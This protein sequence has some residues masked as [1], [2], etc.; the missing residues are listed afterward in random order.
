MLKTSAKVR[1]IAAAFI[2]SVLPL[3]MS[4]REVPSDEEDPYFLLTGQAAEAID[5]CDYESA[6]TR[7]LEAMSLRPDA[8]ENV[9]L[10]S[11]LG[12]VYSYMDKDSLALITF[13]RALEIAPSMRTVLANRAN[14]Y[15]KVGR[16]KDAYRDLGT[17]IEIDSTSVDARYLHG[18]LAIGF[19]DMERAKADMAVVRDADPEGLATAVG[20]STIYTLEEKHLDA[21]PYL[22]RLA[23]ESGREEDFAALAACQLELGKLSDAGATIAKG[24]GKF[25]LSGELY[26]YRARLNRDRYDRKSAEADAKKARQLGIEEARI[27]LLKL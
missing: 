24:M 13:D 18:L 2:L 21:L 27:K 5:S 1:C 12:M 25:P 22:E 14:V 4:A 6:A 23:A 10:M 9:L 11:N 8:P 16:D 17:I 19:G 20:M 15:L 26:Y 7:L 3:A